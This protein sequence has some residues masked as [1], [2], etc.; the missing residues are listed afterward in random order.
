MCD[1]C[2]NAFMRPR[3]HFPGRKGQPMKGSGKGHH[4]APGSP[5]EGLLRMV[6]MVNEHMNRRAGKSVAG[7]FGSG[8]GVK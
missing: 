4:P 7:M 5:W 3:W 2:L 8:G 1:K 6:S